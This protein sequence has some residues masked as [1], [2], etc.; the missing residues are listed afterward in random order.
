ML[1]YYQIARLNRLYEFVKSKEFAELDRKLQ[2]DII[3]SF[4]MHCYH[5]T[6]W[7]I[8]SGIKKENIFG[9]IDKSYELKVCRDLAN[10]TKH[11]GILENKRK[12]SELYSWDKAAWPSPITLSYDYFKKIQGEKNPEHLVLSVSDGEIDCKDFMRDCMQSWNE[13]LDQNNLKDNKFENSYVASS[14]LRL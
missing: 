2:I 7:L 1:Y 14:Y 11:F 3:I 6:D 13:F 10:S 12:Q 4:F 9:F 5:L 8:K